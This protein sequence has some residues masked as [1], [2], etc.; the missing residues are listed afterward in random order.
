VCHI[1][2]LNFL[3]ARRICMKSSLTQVLLF[4]V[5]TNLGYRIFSYANKKFINAF[6][7]AFTKLDAPG[8]CFG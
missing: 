7:G 3:T 8:I 2:A 5:N 1:E 6:V 4:A